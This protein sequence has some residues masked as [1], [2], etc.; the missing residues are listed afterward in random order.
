VLVHRWFKG[1]PCPQLPCLQKLGTSTLILQGIAFDGA[2]PDKNPR[3]GASYCQ[4]R[5]INDNVNLWCELEMNFIAIL[6]N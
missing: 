3:L 4:G 2:L 5:P 1:K 6:I